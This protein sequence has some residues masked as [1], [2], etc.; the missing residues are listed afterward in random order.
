MNFRSKLLHIDSDR[1]VVCVTAWE[2]DKI[3]GNSMGESQSAELAEDRAIMRLQERL[4]KKQE[5]SN[6]SPSMKAR[7][8]FKTKEIKP[9]IDEMIVNSNQ[10]KVLSNKRDKTIIQSNNQNTSNKENMQI[11]LDWS[12]ELAQI[13]LELKRIGWSREVESNYL[14]KTLKVT[15]RARLTDYNLL[16]SYLEQLKSFNPGLQMEE[17]D[18]N[19]ISELLFMESDKILKTLDWGNNEARDYLLK[20]FNCNSRRLLTLDQLYTFNQSLK[21]L[22]K[23]KT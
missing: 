15:S 7:L 12:T 21:V 14:Q 13:D 8:E 17:A 11:P 19:I 9:Q 18:S 3:L 1:V 2:N 20:K 5:N 22:T 16:K 6:T 23:Q 10:D 4:T